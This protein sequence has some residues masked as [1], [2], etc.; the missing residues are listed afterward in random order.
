MSIVV[1]YG[2]KWEFIMGY[3]RVFYIRID[4]W[5]KVKKCYKENFIGSYYV[6]L[7]LVDVNEE[8]NKM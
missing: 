4:F 1:L 6:F 3:F 7:I 5:E 8:L 2:I